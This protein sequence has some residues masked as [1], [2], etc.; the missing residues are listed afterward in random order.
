[1]ILRARDEIH[2]LITHANSHHTDTHIHTHYLSLSHTHT[3]IHSRHNLPHTHLDL[4]GALTTEDLMPARDKNCEGTHVF[5][6]VSVLVHSKQNV[7]VES[8][9]TL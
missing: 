2:A 5:S 8:R 9:R 6:K 4:A 7:P 1:M 3:H